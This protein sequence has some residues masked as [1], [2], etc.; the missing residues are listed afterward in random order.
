MLVKGLG[1]RV[2]II[3]NYDNNNNNNFCGG[4]VNDLR[5]KIFRSYLNVIK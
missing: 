4:F 2:M 5:I 3:I 1:F